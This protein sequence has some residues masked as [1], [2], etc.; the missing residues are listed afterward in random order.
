MNQLFKAKIS[1]EAHELLKLVSAIRTINRFVPQ[2]NNKKLSFKVLMDQ[3]IIRT[4][5]VKAS[6]KFSDLPQKD[7]FFQNS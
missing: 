5:P 7:H 2:T 3:K 1:F 6:I 4:V